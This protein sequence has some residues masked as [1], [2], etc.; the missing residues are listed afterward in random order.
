MA[1]PNVLIAITIGISQPALA[2]SDEQDPGVLGL[3]IMDV[4]IM[5]LH[6]SDPLPRPH[7]AS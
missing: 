5:L 2:V 7:D 1:L 6:S 3:H 4:C